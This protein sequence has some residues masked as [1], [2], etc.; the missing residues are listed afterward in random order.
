MHILLEDWGF[1]LKMKAK[2]SL[3]AERLLLVQVQHTLVLVV[4]N[5]C[6]PAN[7]SLVTEEF[8][9]HCLLIPKAY[10]LYSIKHMYPFGENLWIIL[11]DD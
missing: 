3:W 9:S 10:Q 2:R 5:L 8:V 11:A 7:F 1:E 4:W 6:L